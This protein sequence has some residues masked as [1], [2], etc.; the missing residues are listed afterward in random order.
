M[1]RTLEEKVDPKHAALLVVDVQNDFCHSEGAMA[2]RGWDVKPVQEMVP[3]LLRFLEEARKAKLP[4]IH[5]RMTN[6]E[7][8]MS[9]PWVERRLKHP[10]ASRFSCE[11]GSWGAEF[12]QIEPQPGERIVTKHRY[13]AFVNTDLESILKSKGIQSLILSGVATNVCVES[14]ARD[15]FMQDYYVVFLSDCTATSKLEDHQATLRNMEN[16]FGVVATAQ[17]V[18]QAWA[19]LKQRASA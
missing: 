7:W 12:Y 9:E 8:T 2:R 14:T 15:G 1:L 10:Q 4:I 19:R 18:T 16:H 17:E 5:V 3:R 11:E 13:S 6:N